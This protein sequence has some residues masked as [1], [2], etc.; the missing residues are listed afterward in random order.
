MKIFDSLSSL[1]Q[2]R[3]SPLDPMLREIVIRMLGHFQYDPAE[4]GFVVLV[5][6]G[7]VDRELTDLCLPYRLHEVPFEAVHIT[8][9]Y[10]CGVFLRDNEFAITFLIPDAEWVQGELR[11][12]LENLMEK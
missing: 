11:Q 2:I 7:D 9:G 8:E 10:F 6:P 3:G 5:E 1:N 4:D 12:H